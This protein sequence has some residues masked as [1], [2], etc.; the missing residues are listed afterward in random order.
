MPTM[1]HIVLL[2]AV[3]FFVSSSYGKVIR[4]DQGVLNGTEEYS[5]DGRLFYGF[6]GIPYAKPP[7]DKLRFK[8][9][10]IRAL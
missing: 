7:V 10:G 9:R 4:I 5:R 1:C 8:V 2:F 3:F 6:Y